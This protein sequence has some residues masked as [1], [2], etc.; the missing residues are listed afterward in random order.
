L[1]E[2]TARR[3]WLVGLLLAEQVAAGVVA[4]L[5]VGDRHPQPAHLT[6]G[7]RPDQVVTV[8]VAVV[9]TRRQVEGLVGREWVREVWQ[10]GRGGGGER[11]R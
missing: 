7:R 4:V 2:V 3:M 6:L 9:Q 8:V 11:E 5:G 10:R 1:E